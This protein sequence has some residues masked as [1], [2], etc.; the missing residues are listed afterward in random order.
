MK[1]PIRKTR[2][3]PAFIMALYLGLL[4]T[5]IA[6]AQTPP[7]SS[8]SIP[9]PPSAIALTL[10]HDLSP[11]GMFIAADIVVKA[12]M[13]GL[14]LAS[15]LTW[16]IWFAKAFELLAARRQLRRAIAALNEARSLADAMTQV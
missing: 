14:A 5:T 16:T 13:I 11:W 1:R 6:L 15:V 12:V 9:V 10:P 7:V 8:E 2:L 3:L 4:L